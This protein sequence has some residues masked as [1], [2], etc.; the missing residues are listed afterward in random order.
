MSECT[1]GFLGPAPAMWQASV[2]QKT[3][4]DLGFD[5]LREYQGMSSAHLE[6]L[7]TDQTSIDIDW[8]QGN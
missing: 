8:A 4:A 5:A 6:V 7:A 2:S 3:G 1:H